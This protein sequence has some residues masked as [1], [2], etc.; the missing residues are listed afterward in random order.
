[1]D[2]ARGGFSGGGRDKK[3]VSE[4]ED[5]LEDEVWAMMKS[6][7]D[8]SSSSSSSACRLNATADGGGHPEFS[9]IER[10]ARGQTSAPVGIPDWSRILKKRSRKKL[11]DDDASCDAHN[12][13]DDGY[14]H[15]K[16]DDDDDGGDEM[17]P[18]HE[19]LA[20]RLGSTQ[21]ASFSMC[22]GVG[23]TLKGRDLSKLR[24]AILTKTGFIE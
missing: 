18:P 15:G 16:V 17:V 11:W 21:I 23:R 6:R 20:R 7:E 24:N 19:Y 13:D 10:V 5:L 12:H 22:E 8:S 2:G 1:M 3:T 14:G 4:S 9:A